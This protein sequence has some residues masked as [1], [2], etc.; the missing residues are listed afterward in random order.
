MILQG[1]TIIQ[2]PD[3]I[4]KKPLNESKEWEL[5]FWF[6]GWDPDALSG[7]IVGFIAIPEQVDN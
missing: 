2:D 3:H 1:N 5:E 7:L 6:G 4:L